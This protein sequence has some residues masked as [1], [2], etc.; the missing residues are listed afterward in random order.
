MHLFEYAILF[1]PKDG[2]GAKMLVEIERMFA[3]DEKEVLERAVGRIPPEYLESL[4][5]IAI[6]VMLGP[7]QPTITYTGEAL[8][9]FVAF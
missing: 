6:P 2:V 7:L 8:E 3:K 4:D 1:R 5:E 9:K